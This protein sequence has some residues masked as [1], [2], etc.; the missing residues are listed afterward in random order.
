MVRVDGDKK[1][2]SYSVQY[3]R[4]VSASIAPRFDSRARRNGIAKATHLDGE[5]HANEKR[6]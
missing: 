5:C 2:S 4:V 6:R 3:S 1:Q